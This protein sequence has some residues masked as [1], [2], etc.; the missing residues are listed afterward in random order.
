MNIVLRQRKNPVFHICTLSTTAEV[1]NLEHLIDL[2]T[3]VGDN[4][5]GTGD[6]AVSI[7]RTAIVNCNFAATLHSHKA[8]RSSGCATINCGAC[9]ILM[10][11]G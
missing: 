4:G 1:S 9:R 3:A 10:F 7:Q 5:A 2:C 8:A 6:K 11:C